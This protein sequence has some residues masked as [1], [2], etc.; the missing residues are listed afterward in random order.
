LNKEF[1]LRLVVEDRGETLVV[2]GRN[3]TFSN[4]RNHQFQVWQ[5]PNVFSRRL[6]N[7]Y[8]LL[9]AQGKNFDNF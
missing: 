9:M 8:H 1:I 4:S 6:N 3:S 7:N 5:N 2:E